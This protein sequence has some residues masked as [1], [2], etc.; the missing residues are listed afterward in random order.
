MYSRNAA[1]VRRLNFLNR[2]LDGHERKSLSFC[3]NYVRSL[4]V[5]T[6]DNV[7]RELKEPQHPEYVPRNYC[8]CT[9]VGNRNMQMALVISSSCGLCHASLLL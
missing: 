1:T 3:K 8:K 9:A 2:I 4:S 5:L 6:I 7:S